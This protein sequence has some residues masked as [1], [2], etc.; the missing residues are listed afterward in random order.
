MK[1][2]LTTLLLAGI[3]LFSSCEKEHNEAST[4]YKLDETKSVAEWQGF[5]RNSYFNA[6]SISVASEELEVVNGQV[7]SG[8]FVLPLSSLVN[9]NLPDAQKPL[10]I[11]HLQSADFF[12]MALHPNLRFTITQVSRY[13]SGD[14]KAVSGAN[15]MVTGDL[16]MLD[17]THSISFPAK[18]NVNKQKITVQ[19]DVQVDRTRWGITYAS[20]PSLP[21]EHYILPEIKLHL[22]LQ[23][24]R[25]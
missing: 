12:N 1:F 3:T 7:T 18:I 4:S 5:L 16:T 6:G 25:E 11:G 20:D 8:R 14:T 17:Q 24:G 23:G 15:Y 13:T 22:D 19:A 9:F 10:L 2:A 21:D